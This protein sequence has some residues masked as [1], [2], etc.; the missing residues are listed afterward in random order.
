MRRFEMFWWKMQHAWCDVKEA[1]GYLFGR[2]PVQGPV[3]Q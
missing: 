1:V 3:P 2:E